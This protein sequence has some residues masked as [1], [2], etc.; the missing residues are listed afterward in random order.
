MEGSDNLDS[1]APDF[2]G[3]GPLR[4]GRAG[5]G[6]PGD[7]PQPLRRSVFEAVRAAGRIPRVEVARQLGVSPG[8]V[9]AAA[10]E[11]LQSGY[12]HEVAALPA[13]GVSRGRPPV[14]LAVQPCSGYVAGLKISDAGHS[15]VIHDFAGGQVAALTLPAEALRIDRAQVPALVE[16]LLDEVT[17]R[18]GLSR[19][20]LAAVGLGLPGFVESGDGVV[21]WSPF[22]EGRTMPLA[23]EVSDRIGLPVLIDNDANLVTLAELWFGSGRSVSNF[24]VVTIEYGVGMGLVLENR[25]YRGARGLGTELGHTKVQLDGALCRCG[26]RG[27]VE[28]YVADY[29][30]VREASTALGLQPGRTSA[31]AMLET[32]YDRAKGGNQAARSIFRRAGRYL[33]VALGNVVNLFD[34]EM[35]LLSGDRMR[36]DYLYADEVL[37]EMLQLSIQVDRPA[38]QV[39]IHAWG[40]LI[41]ARGAAALAL[42][43]VTAARLGTPAQVAAQ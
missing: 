2:A 11:L 32:L 34:P 1:A 43:E 31:A 27:C 18:A 30:L 28:A 10:A 41:W 7:G 17:A 42:G 39:R 19:D 8:S 3:C 6:A 16:A 5:A 9:T 26:Q 12:L 35:I 22:V 33:A 4:A 15:A 40:G 13:G 14:A 20:D 24:A 23:A 36:Y 37:A 29:A 25:L 21:L 38:P